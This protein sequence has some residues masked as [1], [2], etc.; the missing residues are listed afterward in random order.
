M[1]TWSTIDRGVQQRVKALE[2]FLADVFQHL[3]YAVRTTSVT[4]DHGAD[5]LVERDGRRIAVQAKGYVAS[6]VGNKAVQEAHFG[7]TFYQC[8]GCAVVTNSKF[9]GAAIVA[10]QRSGCV[11]IDG[12]AIPALI[13]GE[14]T[15]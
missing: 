5:L 7:Q 11:L 14:I 13:R 12:A 4:G 6:T 10:G 15:L 9:T 2:R 8:T 1:D 3:G